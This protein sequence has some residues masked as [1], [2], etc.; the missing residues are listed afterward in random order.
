EDL[1]GQVQRRRLPILIVAAAVLAVSAGYA[2]RVTV[3]MEPRAFFKPGSEPALAQEFLDSRFGGSQFLQVAVEG[4]ITHPNSLRELRRL[5]HYARSLPGVTQLQTIVDPLLLVG[6]AMGTGKGLPPER[7]Q[8]GN[9]L[10][11]IEGEPA[12]RQLLTQDRRSALL[13]VRVSGDAR[14][15]LQGLEQY[16]ASRWPLPPRARTA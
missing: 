7:R 15:P 8:V 13:H 6:D 14:A 12:V 10:F 9:L 1:W 4:D 2:S 11:F 16:L 3:R 5:G